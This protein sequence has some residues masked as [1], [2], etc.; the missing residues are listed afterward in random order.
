MTQLA[1]V[2]IAFAA[3]LPILLC[4]QTPTT[5]APN[6]WSAV[7]QE[8]GR[9]GAVQSDGAIKFGFPRSDLTVRIG[10]ITLKP[11]FALGSWVAF[12]RSNGDAMMMG[13]LVLLES[14]IPE[15]TEV[16]RKGG[17]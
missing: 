15:V 1:R 6:Q 5:Q 11:A 17:I 13:D 7:E 9:P 16:L 14:E 3:I 10:D 2:T 12:A 4:A 8:L